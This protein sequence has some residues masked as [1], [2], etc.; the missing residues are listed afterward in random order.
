MNLNE[1]VM[2]AAAGL[3]NEDTQ[4]GEQLSKI[5]K[6]AEYSWMSDES[7]NR[8]DAEQ[9]HTWVRQV[10]LDDPN[11][12]DQRYTKDKVHK[13]FCDAFENAQKE[14]PVP[15]TWCPQMYTKGFDTFTFGC[16]DHKYAF[17]V[18]DVQKNDPNYG[19][20]N[21]CVYVK[22]PNIKYPANPVVSAFYVKKDTIP[23]EAKSIFRITNRLFND[24]L[25][26]FN[27]DNGFVL[28]N[29][30][31]SYRPMSRRLLNG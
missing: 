2:N 26:K 14:N 10:P 4:V 31:E 29:K 17:D 5:P 28:K 23:N 7:W 9:Q 6:P 11:W 15:L 1:W 24:G 16:K 18:Y 21:I 8:M 30:N 27:K 25:E 20:A 19:H 3:L 13:A 12:N 22:D